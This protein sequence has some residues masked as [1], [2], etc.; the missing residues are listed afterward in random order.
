MEMEDCGFDFGRQRRVYTNGNTNH[1]KENSCLYSVV[2]IKSNTKWQL[3]RFNRY[4]Q[5]LTTFLLL[6]TW[7]FYFVC[8]ETPDGFVIW[9][10]YYSKLY[11]TVWDNQ[12][13]R[14]RLFYFSVIWDVFIY[15]L[16]VIVWECICECVWNYV[17][18]LTSYIFSSVMQ[19]MCF[20]FN[21][22]PVVSFVLSGIL[23]FKYLLY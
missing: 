18:R 20:P 21:I 1:D 12:V 6:Q 23:G 16:S 19:Y 7:L 10:N 22:K 9:N 14:E 8:L 17:Q 11:N 4:I 15:G 13:I 3:L 2:F 5:T